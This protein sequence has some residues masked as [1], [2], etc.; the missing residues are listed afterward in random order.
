VRRAVFANLIGNALKYTQAGSVVVRLRESEGLVWAS[1][2][3]SGLGIPT[4]AQPHLFE[5]FF[6]VSGRRHAGLGGTG[7]G[8]TFCKQVI[9]AHGG[10]IWVESLEPKATRHPGA[11]F[12]FTLAS[13]PL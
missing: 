3:D 12:H 13:M 9:E 10:R 4:E 1:V 7:L 11:T 5:K 2:A 8:L 6:Q